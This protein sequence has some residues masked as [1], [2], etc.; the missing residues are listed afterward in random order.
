MKIR[1]AILIIILLVCSSYLSSFERLGKRQDISQ[2]GQ[3]GFYSWIISLLDLQELGVGFL[4]LQFDQDSLNLLGNY[5]RLLITLD[6]ITSL[7]PGEFDAWS[8]KGYMRLDRGL[9][10]ND[11]AMVKR[12]MADYQLACELNKNDARFYND[13]AQAF[14]FKLKDPIKALEYSK[15]AIAIENH[16]W[17]TE[18]ILGYIS[19]ELGSYTRA[20]EMQQA[21]LKYDDL[22]SYERSVATK[23][24]KRLQQIL[25][26]RQK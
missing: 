11:Q 9:K 24:K 1:L 13:A 23:H 14:L 20:L 12:A 16:S 25:S 7:D 26:N 8:L 15:Q 6:G 22:P 2:L 10:K 17:K 5:H 21:I 4:W 3:A 18:K 19:E